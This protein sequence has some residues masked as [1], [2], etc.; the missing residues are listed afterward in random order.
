MPTAVLTVLA[1]SQQGERQ[2]HC[3]YAYLFRLAMS[4][5]PQAARWAPGALPPPSAAAD[6]ADVLALFGWGPRAG[7][8]PISAAPK[9]ASSS[10]TA[11][12]GELLSA[13]KRATDAEEQV[14]EQAAPVV[15]GS[16]RNGT[17]EHSQRA[18]ASSGAPLAVGVAPIIADGIGERFGCFAPRR[19]HTE[20]SNLGADA[21]RPTQQ[22]RSLEHRAQKRVEA[23]L[24]RSM[25]PRLATW[26][27][28][29]HGRTRTAGNLLARRS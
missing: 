13:Q 10:V 24:V 23:A 16:L 18:A 9:A 19:T 1:P 15:R 21:H 8:V 17:S 5:L 26:L 28:C 22:V 29:D 14:A 3:C 11:P 25:T 12:A 27:K 20:I 7:V 2:R 4:T 6:H